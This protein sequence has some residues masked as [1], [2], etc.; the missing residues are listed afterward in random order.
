MKTKIGIK[1]II[2]LPI[3]GIL[4]LGFFLF[5]LF[6]IY[7]TIHNPELIGLI[8]GLMFLWLSVGF[9]TLLLDEL[10]S[11]EIR[12]GTLIIRKTL[13]GNKTLVELSKVKY[14]EYDWGEMYWTKMNG[15]LL[16]FDSKRTIQVNRVNF[17]NSN[18]FIE[19]IKE[20]CPNDKTIKPKFDYRKLKVF[21]VFGII[22]L[23]LLLIYKLTE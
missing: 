23:G 21:A 14:S 3:L 2:L 19:M 18:E 20:K 6:I 15:I 13:L 12:N 10:R 4:L 1:L 7:K 8:A 16:Q 17:R 5:G 11:F 22:I 9:S